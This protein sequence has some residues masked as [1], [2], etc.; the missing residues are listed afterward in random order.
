M[1]SHALG[2]R[3]FDPCSLVVEF[4]P[5]IG[6]LCLPD[7]HECFVLLTWS[8]AQQSGISFLLGAELPNFAGR[9]IA[10]T[11]LNA[12]RSVAISICR[13]IPGAAFFTLWAN[14]FFLSQSIS[15]LERS[16]A[17]GM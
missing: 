8:E 17:S 11:K 6:F 15:N 16:N 12:N 2:E 4:F 5:L 13:W 14:H 10:L 3:A 9:A 7:F 1:G